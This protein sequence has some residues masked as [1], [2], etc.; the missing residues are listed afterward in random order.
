M[1]RLSALLLASALGFF[2]VVPIA[3]TPATGITAT[4]ASTVTWAS[5]FTAKFVRSASGIINETNRVNSAGDQNPWT[6]ADVYL[7]FRPLTGPDGTGDPTPNPNCS[8][9]G[10]VMAPF[11]YT[12][13][14]PAIAGTPD[15]GYFIGSNPYNVCVYLVDPVVATGTFS[16]SAVN[17]VTA[18]LPTG[19]N[20]HFR[21]TISGTW[22]NDSLNVAD[23]EYT[24]I[25]DW[26]NVQN[27][28]DVSPYLLGEGWGDVQID[29]AFVNWGTY[30]STHVYSHTVVAS[31]S[32]NLAVFDGDSGTNIKNAGWYGDNVGSL[33]Y[34][35]TYL[36]L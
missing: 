32:I 20:G 21:V 4:P 5:T 22:T 3:A 15:S 19:L 14:D 7:Q 33:T 31:G 23:A 29:G 6:S 12:N 10:L 26:S 2:V 24:G 27:G 16:S 25:P 36:G 30:T 18:T 34:T 8:T 9:K 28:Y 35:I 11:I 1:R 17:G 13:S